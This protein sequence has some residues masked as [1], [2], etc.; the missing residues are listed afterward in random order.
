[1]TANGYK[2]NKSTELYE[3]TVKH[4]GKMVVIRAVPVPELDET[5]FPTGNDIYYTCDPKENVN[6][7]HID[8]LSKSKNPSGLCM[9][10][11]FIKDPLTSKNISKKNRFYK[12]IGDN[13]KQQQS[14]TQTS[15]II[16]DILYILQDTNKLQEGR[17]G[18]LPKYLDVF[19]NVM[20][21]NKK[22]LSSHYLVSTTPRYLFKMGVLQSDSP[23]MN[24]VA[25][26]FNM[27][28]QELKTRLIEAL[29]KDKTEQIFTSLNNGDIKTQYR[30][31]ENYID[32]IHYN[33]FF[34]HYTVMDLMSI[35]GVL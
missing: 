1:L 11:C 26:L 24:S 8:F 20:A 6:H 3:K 22:A 33:I 2:L 25:A 32:F 21:G 23:F 14:Q 17:L 15:K 34:D 13:S 4:K 18:Y 19:L 5:G 10:C 28:V 27:T 35:P 9:P 31:K 12:C 16:G 30:T 29:K 7:I